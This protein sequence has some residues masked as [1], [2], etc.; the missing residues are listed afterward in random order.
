MK[1]IVSDAGPLI[2]LAKTERL[3]LLENFF[4]Y[5]FITPVV[6]KEITQKNDAVK[7]LL[8]HADFIKVKDITKP[9]DYNTLLKLLD[10]GEASAIVLAKE[11]NTMLLIDETPMPSFWHTWG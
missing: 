11:Q 1:I 8:E 5:V 2:I 7:D 10:A 4:S 9:Q 3:D 6:F